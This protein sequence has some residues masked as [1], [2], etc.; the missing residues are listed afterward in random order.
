MR[1]QEPVT[2][3]SAERADL[4][5]DQNAWRTLRMRRD[6]DLDKRAYSEVDGC[7]KGVCEHAFMVLTPGGEGSDVWDYLVR[8]ARQWKQESL[9]HVDANG[10]ASI[11]MVDTERWGCLGTMRVVDEA[12]AKASNAFTRTQDGR[13]YVAA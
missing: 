3:I 2:I 4:P 9:L 7:Y 12:T 10:I 13:Y 8:K 5:A 1:T 11:Y 6:L